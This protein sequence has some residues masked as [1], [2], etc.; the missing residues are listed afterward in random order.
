MT[1]SASVSVKHISRHRKLH[2]RGVIYFLDYHF[3]AR[4]LK[5]DGTVLYYDGKCPDGKP[6]VDGNLS[7]M[8]LKDWGMREGAVAVMGLYS[9]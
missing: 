2:L 7:K 8:A 9:K 6:V 4:V 1:V 5:L 3:T